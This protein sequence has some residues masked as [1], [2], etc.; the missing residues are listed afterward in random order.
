MSAP[1]NRLIRGVLYAAAI[2]AVLLGLR[3]FGFPLVFVVVLCATIIGVIVSRRSGA[4]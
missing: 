3:F 1:T 2:L 4:S